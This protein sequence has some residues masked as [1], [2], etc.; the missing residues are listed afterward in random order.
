MHLS[1]LAEHAAKLVAIL[2]VTTEVP[3]L[4]ADSVLFKRRTSRLLHTPQVKGLYDKIA[5]SVL[6][7]SDGSLDIRISGNRDYRNIRVVLLH[8]GNQLDAIHARELD[9]R[10]DEIDICFPQLLQ[11]LLSRRHGDHGVATVGVQTH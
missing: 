6:E 11:R 3:N 2:E 8:V 4:H 5:G 10:N 7:H 9:V 1:R